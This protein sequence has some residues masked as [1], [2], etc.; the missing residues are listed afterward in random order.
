MLHGLDLRRVS[1]PSSSQAVSEK[2]D[3]LLLDCFISPAVRQRATPSRD[4]WASIVDDGPSR[5]PSPD[6]DEA[7]TAQLQR[8]Q[9]LQVE[10]RNTALP[11]LLAAQLQNNKRPL[12]G[13]GGVSQAPA[14]RAKGLRSK[15]L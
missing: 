14:W 7:S 2:S 5:Q 12:Q 15:V 11:H 8:I 10:L 13:L 3:R 4:M 9:E 1:L 6:G